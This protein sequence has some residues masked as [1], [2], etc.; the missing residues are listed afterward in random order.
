[1]DLAMDADYLR[2]AIIASAA[3]MLDER[4]STAADIPTTARE[5][6]PR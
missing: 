1:M 2:G 5:R 6:Y 3:G 4:P